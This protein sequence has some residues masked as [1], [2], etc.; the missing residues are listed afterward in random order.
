MAFNIHCCIIFVNSFLH[1][2]SV[3]LV[4]RLSRMYDAIINIAMCLSINNIRV[5]NTTWHER[6]T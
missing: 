3:P 6:L 5:L 1:N 2:Y 4:F